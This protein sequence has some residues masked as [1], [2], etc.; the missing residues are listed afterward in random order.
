MVRADSAATTVKNDLSKI[1]RELRPRLLPVLLPETDLDAL[2]PRRAAST[3][4]AASSVATSMKVLSTTVRSSIGR[5]Q[6]NVERRA[7]IHNLFA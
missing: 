7:T 1:Y 4:T 5:T 3:R 6:R 2:G